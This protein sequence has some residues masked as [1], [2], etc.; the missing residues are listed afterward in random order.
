MFSEQERGFISLLD[1][2]IMKTCESIPIVANT[3]GVMFKRL[4][5]ES[6]S[7][8]FVIYRLLCFVK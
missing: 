4:K 1:S 3:D 8:K 2:D 5:R 7:P 6:Y